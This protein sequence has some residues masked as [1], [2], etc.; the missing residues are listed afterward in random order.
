[1]A[2]PAWGPFIKYSCTKVCDSCH[3]LSNLNSHFPLAL[4]F[5]YFVT[6]KTYLVIFNEMQEETKPLVKNFV[7]LVTTRFDCK[8]NAIR[9]DNDLEF[10]MH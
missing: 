4:L 10:F 2:L 7:A 9:S 6:H 8:L 5:G 3:L 1:M